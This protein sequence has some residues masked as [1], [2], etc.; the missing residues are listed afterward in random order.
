GYLDDVPVSKVGAF[1]AGLHA[2]A[3]ANAQALLDRIDQTGDYNDEIEAELKK[4]VEG[5]KTSGAY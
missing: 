4:I 3:H 2:Y 1:E 5:F